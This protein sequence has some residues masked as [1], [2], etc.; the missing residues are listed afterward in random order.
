MAGRYMQR[1][2][3]IAPSNAMACKTC[4]DRKRLLIPSIPVWFD[5]RSLSWASVHW[6]CKPSRGPGVDSNVVHGWGHALETSLQGALSQ[7]QKS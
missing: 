6:S 4:I 1:Y 3:A 7:T 2:R 5:C